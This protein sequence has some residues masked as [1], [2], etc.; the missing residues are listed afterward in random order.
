MART[1]GGRLM[2][3]AALGVGWL[4]RYSLR[5]AFRG[6]WLQG[7]VPD[8]PDG[9]V[10][11]LNHNLWWDVYLA[12]LLASYHKRP[13]IGWL[14]NWQP[15]PPFGSAGALPFPPG[16]PAVRAAT[17]RR[18]V[19]LL[20]HSRSLLV[21]YPEGVLHDDA[22]VRPFGRALWWLREHLPGVLFIPG[23]THAVF[24]TEQRPVLR[25]SL[26]QPMPEEESEPL[27]LESARKRVVTLREDLAHRPAS[28]IQGMA[29]MLEGYESI[30]TRW[31]RWMTP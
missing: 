31:K 29:C 6:I 22:D 24:G 19:R 2:R 8:S 5:Q 10:V 27:W 11:F 23:A 7:H 3:P 16:N 30:D 21:L 15:F 20:T 13:L 14:E 18:T 9:A 12:W 17:M 26:G 4:A 25:V 28:D 1:I